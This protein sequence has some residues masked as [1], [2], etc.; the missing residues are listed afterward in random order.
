MQ[1][2]VLGYLSGANLYGPTADFLADVDSERVYTWLDNYCRSHQLDQIVEAA[3][4]L[5]SALKARHP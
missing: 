1:A 4:Q 3:G 2:F 5:V